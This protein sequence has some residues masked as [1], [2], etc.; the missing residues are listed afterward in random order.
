MAFQIPIYES[1]RGVY[2]CFFSIGSVFSLLLVCIG[3]ILTQSTGSC[4]K[5][6]VCTT[7]PS[8]LFVTVCGA[9]VFVLVV[10]MLEMLEMLDR[11]TSPC[12]GGFALA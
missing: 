3:R 11:G 2:P 12:I 5:H 8:I 7:R 4:Y 6:L 1:G 9:N 10:E